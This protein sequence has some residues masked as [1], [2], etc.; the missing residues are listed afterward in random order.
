MLSLVVYSEKGWQ[1]SGM[2]ASAFLN[3]ARV[4]PGPAPTTLFAPTT[5]LIMKPEAVR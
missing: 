5:V 3:S 4:Q 2:E 1:P